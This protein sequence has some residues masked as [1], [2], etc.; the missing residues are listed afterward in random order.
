MPPRVPLDPTGRTRLGG[1]NRRLP[2]PCRPGRRWPTGDVKRTYRN[3]ET[4]AKKTR[5]DLDG[6]DVKDTVGNAG[7]EARRV[8]GNVG[9]DIRTTDTKQDD[10]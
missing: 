3:I 9:D 4:D 6:T 7:D 1:K 10:R 5:R 2:V 8:L